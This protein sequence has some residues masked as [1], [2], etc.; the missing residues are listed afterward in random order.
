MTVYGFKR[1]NKE[2]CKCKSGGRLRKQKEYILYAI[3]KLTV[4]PDVMY[5]FK[6]KNWLRN[7][8]YL[9]KYA[10]IISIFME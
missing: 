5:F 3:K 7:N 4:L 2:A 8:I 1:K 6:F 10:I 9:Y